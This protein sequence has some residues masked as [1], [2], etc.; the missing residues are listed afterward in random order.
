MLSTNPKREPLLTHT[1][2]PHG[3]L[4]EHAMQYLYLLFSHAVMVYSHY[5]EMS[6]FFTQTRKYIVPF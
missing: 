3:A 6:L 4:P 2:N 5:S 1:F